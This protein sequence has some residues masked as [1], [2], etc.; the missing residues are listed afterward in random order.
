MKRFF[1]VLLALTLMFS[2]L[3]VMP[4]KAY[5]ATNVE[6]K[7]TAKPIDEKGR[8]KVETRVSGERKEE[9]KNRHDEV[10]VMVDGSY[11]G[12][13]DWST[14][15]NA[16]LKIGKTVLGGTGNNTL[17]T[18]MAFGIGDNTVLKHVAS[19]EKLDESLTREPGNLLY[20][21]SS[22][23]N[24][25]AGLRGISEYI[26][27]HD[28]TLNK[29]YVVYVSDSEVNSDE[30]RYV[31]S[32][33]TQNDWLQKDALSLAK[34]SMEEEVTK[35]QEG[36]AE[37]SNA[38][39]TV[40]SEEW[41]SQNPDATDDDKVMAWADLVWKDVYEY[42]GMSLDSAYAISDTERA[43]VRYDKENSTHIREIFYYTIWGRKCPDAAI[44]ASEAGHE[45]AQKVDHLYMVDISSASSW[46]ADVANSESNV[47]LFTTLDD[48]VIKNSTN[49]VQEEVLITDYTSKWVN[50][51]TTTVK[52]VDNNLGKTI[53]TSK[54]GWLISEN[55]PASRE[56]LVTIEMVS[57]DN[58]EAG[59]SNVVGNENDI[60]YK[61]TWYVDDGKICG[62]YNYSLVYEISVDIHEKGFK[63]NTNYPLN[64]HSTIK[65][66]KKIGDEVTSTIEDLAVPKVWVEYVE[67]ETKPKP[68]ETTPT[69]PTPTETT[70]TV[71]MPTEP[72][73][74]DVT[75]K[76]TW[77]DENNKYGKRPKRIT[78]ILMADDKQIASKKVT[79]DDNW[80]YTFR[81]LPKYNSE[82]EEIKYTV[83]EKQVANYKAKIDGYNIKNIYNKPESNPSNPDSKNPNNG[84]YI[85]IAVVI[86]IISGLLLFILFKKKR[87]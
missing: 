25:E 63:Y 78:I 40:N 58:Y 59:G 12:E 76:K 70:Q 69:V 80:K 35:Y 72:E 74:I 77:Q 8:F 53:W 75:G 55:R 32:N 2:A 17:M 20:G 87:K 14:T 30:S 31:F 1:A 67:P 29:V 52:V 23:T 65:Y 71:P 45:L 6:N 7:K 15:R 9:E 41:E 38:Y 11:S 5:A 54:E 46:M 10:I 48:V 83:T 22:S 51:D 13:D 18:I 24:C 84:D 85:M 62:C 19:V 73:T 66:T 43:F 36:K 26:T 27:N 39:L 64:G 82:G 79:A 50:L 68:I 21:R 56:N 44:R 16:I 81:N 60:I 34:W 61:L 42:S 4:T 33:W 57:T 28:S 47:S 49:S 86:M 37:L 3:A